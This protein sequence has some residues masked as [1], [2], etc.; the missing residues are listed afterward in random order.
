MELNQQTFARTLERIKD[1]ARLQDNMLT[2]EQ[3]NEAFEELELNEEQM[4]LILQHLFQCL[5]YM[6]KKL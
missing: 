1:T 5:N 3:I 4:S 2:S 6:K